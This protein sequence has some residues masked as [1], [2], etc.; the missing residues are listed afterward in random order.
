MARLR[1]G[2]GD[3]PGSGKELNENILASLEFL[4]KVVTPG[5]EMINPGL[6]GVVIRA[7]RLDGKAAAPAVVDEGLHWSFAPDI[8]LGVSPLQDRGKGILAIAKNVG[9]DSD[10]FAGDAFDRKAAGVDLRSDRFDDDSA[11]TAKLGQ[12]S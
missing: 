10:F 4:F 1:D 5:L 7:K 8:C 2:L 3:Q 11:A 6:D 12:R 9:V